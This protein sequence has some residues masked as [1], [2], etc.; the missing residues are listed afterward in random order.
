MAERGAFNLPGEGSYEGLVAMKVCLEP[1]CPVLVRDG[2][3]CP[4]HEKDRE[5]ARGRRQ[6][7]GYDA[8]H[9]HLRAE[10]T[11]KVATGTIRCGNPNCRRVIAPGERWDLGHT[12]ERRGY[13]GPEH[14]RC[15]RSEGGRAAHQ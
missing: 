8:E 9:D 15:N 5:R 6:S 3:R 2:S 1:G 12:P 13:R 11:P 4:M 7:R 10:W 14:E